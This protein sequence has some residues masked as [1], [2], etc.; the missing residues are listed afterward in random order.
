MARAHHQR[1][2][3]RIGV[4]ASNYDDVYTLKFYSQFT[5]HLSDLKIICSQSIFAVSICTS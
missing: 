1:D 3:R 5:F 4:W 2:G